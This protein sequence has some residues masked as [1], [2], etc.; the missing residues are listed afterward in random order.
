MF[1]VFKF[2]VVPINKVLKLINFYFLNNF[3]A[4]NNYIFDIFFTSV[5]I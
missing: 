4:E 5:V 2:N 1:M 3:L